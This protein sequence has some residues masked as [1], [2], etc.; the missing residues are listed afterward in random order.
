MG[1]LDKAAAFFAPKERKEEAAPASTSQSTD[2]SASA[3]GKSTPSGSKPP[4]FPPLPKL[5]SLPVA[6]L[7]VKSTA[8]GGTPAADA[9]STSTN[10]QPA[11]TEGQGEASQK[12]SFKEPEEASTS[13]PNAG[14]SLRHFRAQSRKG[15]WEAGSAVAGTYKPAGVDTILHTRYIRATSKVTSC[16]KESKHLLSDMKAMQVSEPS[17]LQSC[18]LSL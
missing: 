11:D 1:F 2:K 16:I 18:R 10:A 15:K 5:P 7:P 6:P 12:V 8:E 3:P 13:E 9:P 4:A 14:K 17:L